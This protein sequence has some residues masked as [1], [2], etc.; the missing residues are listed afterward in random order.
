[1]STDLSYLL[2][3][4]S[5]EDIEQELDKLWR[6]ELWDSSSTLHQDAVKKGIDLAKL[7]DLTR[8]DA[9]SIKRTAE[10]LG[11]ETVILVIFAKAL[12]PVVADALRDLWKEIL[13]PRLR[14]EKGSGRIVEKKR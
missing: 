12:A 6:G 8:A 10:G 2:K 5:E 14:R 9:I 13:L 4:L 11:A 1:M 3:G 7:K